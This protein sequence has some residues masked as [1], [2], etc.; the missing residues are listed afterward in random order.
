MVAALAAVLIAAL[1]SPRRTPS[2][3]AA[4]LRSPQILVQSTAAVRGVRRV[5]RG[6][7]IRFERD[8]CLGFAPTVHPN[9]V[10]VALDPGHGGVDP[11]ATAVVAGRRL[12]EKQVTLAVGKRA[13]S[14]LRGAGYRVVMSRVRDSTVASHGVADLHEGI[15]TP[16]AAQ[17]EIEAR[18]LCANAA[19]AEALIAIHMNAFSDPSALGTETVYC[20]SRPFARRSRRLANLIQRA[21]LA[22]LRGAGMAAL[23]RGVLPDSAAGGAAL[24]PQTAHYGHLIELGPADR[25]WLPYPSLMPGALVEP[26]FLSNPGEASF[27]LS[28]RGQEALARALLVALDAFF[29][30]TG[31]A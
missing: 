4:R 8:A 14:S 13:L 26:V 15:L 10:T 2:P 11:G 6:E 24:T 3:A 7:P 1:S 17:R 28:R 21:T 30:R 29:A 5:G 9:G 31:V 18:N 25:P 20:P 12:S 16:D 27:V 19:H 22:A 23:S